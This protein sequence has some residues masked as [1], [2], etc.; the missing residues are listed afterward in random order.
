MGTGPF[1]SEKS[2]RYAWSN[3]ASRAYYEKKRR[4]KSAPPHTETLPYQAERI[5][6]AQKALPFPDVWPT[7][8][9]PNTACA[10]AFVGGPGFVSVHN[11]SLERCYARFRD[12]MGKT[13]ALGTAMAELDSSFQMIESRVMQAYASVRA[14][15]QGDLRGA[16]GHIG[17]N[18]RSMPKRYQIPYNARRNAKDI[19]GAW[20]EYWFG[21]APTINDVNTALDVIQKVPKKLHY[22]VVGTAVDE[23]RLRDDSPRSQPGG[24]W[25][26]HTVNVRVDTRMIGEV[27]I[28][29]PSLRLAHDLGFTNPG[30]I[31]YEIIPFSWLLDWVVP[32][33]GFLDQIDQYLGLSFENPV[34][35]TRVDA[36]EEWFEVGW[37]GDWRGGHPSLWAHATASGHFFQRNIGVPTAW[38]FPT[39]RFPKLSLT[40]ASTAISLLVGQLKG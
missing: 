35:S 19:G 11:H 7:F 27:S 32:I 36:E 20:L 8:D 23:V 22:N 12:E 26:R 34:F 30:K 31:I 29:N 15:R 40:R 18:P 10:G 3:S 17:L 39:A 5:S 9:A 21:W 4:Y 16:A 1:I 14:L 28:T 37:Y 25:T 24:T 33:G 2:M 38:S 13:A 6:C